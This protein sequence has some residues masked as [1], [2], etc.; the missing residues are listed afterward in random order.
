[1]SAESAIVLLPRFTT[2]VGATTFTTAPLDVSSYGSL[3][4]QVWRGAMRGTSPTF[5]MYLEESLDCEQWVVG[6]AAPT[7]YV[8]GA[9]PPAEPKFFSYAFRLRWFRV[10]VVLGGTDPVATCWAEGLLR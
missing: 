10:R 8:V 7:A 6:P 2:L 3:Q 4:V 9:S 5:T 1:M